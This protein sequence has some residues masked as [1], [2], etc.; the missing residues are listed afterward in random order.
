MAKM[1]QVVMEKFAD[2]EA[3]KFMATVDD[4]GVPNV[5]PILSLMPF[6][7]DK[8]VFVDIMMNKTRK[9]L[10]SNGKVAASVLTKDGISYQVKG[11]RGFRPRAR[12]SR[13]S[14][15]TRCSST[16]HTPDRAP[17]A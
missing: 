2:M 11:A 15:H 16:T 5:A 1:P 4:E 3:A 17:S 12:F 7:E 9:N 14:P 8:L 10:L 13:C 6:G